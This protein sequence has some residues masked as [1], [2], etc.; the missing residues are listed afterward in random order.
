MAACGSPFFIGAGFCAGDFLS[1]DMAER[2]VRHTVSSALRLQ[3][4][5]VILWFT[6]QQKRRR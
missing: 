2:F 1:G 3:A 6:A 4:I 5:L